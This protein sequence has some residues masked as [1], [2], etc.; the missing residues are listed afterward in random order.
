MLDMDSNECCI[1]FSI[2]VEPIRM[3]CSHV[4][5]LIC[6]EKLIISGDHRC[7]MDRKEFDYTKDLKFDKSIVERNLESDPKGFYERANRIYEFRQNVTNMEEMTLNFGNFHTLLDT[8]E[9]NK[10]H[11]TAFVTLKKLDNRIS[12]V[13]ESLKKEANIEM[14]INTDENE[15]NQKKRSEKPSFD[16][17]SADKIIKRVIFKLHPSFTQ[18]IIPVTEAPFKIT[19]IGWGAFNITIVV[20][21][22]D[23]LNI[24][25][26]ELDH[27]L[28]F[29]KD[30]T[31]GYRKIFVDMNKVLED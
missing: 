3:A 20:E 10:H 28:C 6:L 21:F 23:K 30:L 7:P 13:V 29:N 11:W 17:I 8:T 31:E 1:C 12:D 14:Y 15:F 26:V 25:S 19:R 24:E 27:F 2:L 22:H 4:Y 5:C 9:E 18:N 16:E